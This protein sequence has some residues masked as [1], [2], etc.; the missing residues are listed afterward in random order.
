MTSLAIHGRAGRYLAMA[1]VAIS[2]AFGAMLTT[3]PDAFAAKTEAQI[4]AGCEKVG[5]T[6][7]TVTGSHHTV[8]TCVYTNGGGTFKVH[9]LDGESIGGSKIS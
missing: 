4:K 5:G 2:L 8:S 1:G 9:Y 6:Y 3:A 7:T